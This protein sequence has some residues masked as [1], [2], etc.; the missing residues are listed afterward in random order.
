M[1]PSTRFSRSWSTFWKLLGSKRGA[2][3]ASGVFTRGFH[4]NTVQLYLEEQRWHDGCRM[5]FWVPEGQNPDEAFSLCFVHGHQRCFTLHCLFRFCQER[6][7]TP[8]EW[9]LAMAKAVPG[10]VDAT[11]KTLGQASV[12]G[13]AGT[14]QR[15]Q[16]TV[17]WSYVTVCCMLNGNKMK[18]E[19]R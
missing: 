4:F 10:F 2:A 13:L 12:R 9:A 1:S 15:S 3:T 5:H 19:D 8:P 11:I 7:V 14:I 6:G 17:A 16:N 18:L